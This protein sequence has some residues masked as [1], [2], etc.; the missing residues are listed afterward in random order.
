MHPLPKYRILDLTSWNRKEHFEFFNAFDQ[1]YFGLQT[2]VDVTGAKELCKTNGWSF[3]LF[4]HFLS[5]KAVNSVEAFKLRLVNEEIRIYENLHVNTNQF[6]EDRTFAFSFIPFEDD[7]EKF[8]NVGRKVQDAVNQSTGLCLDENTS[9]PDSIHYSTIPWVS[10]TGLT[11]ARNS[12]YIDSVPKISFGKLSR[13]DDKFFL[14]V[15]IH[16]H[17][18]LVDGYDVG[19]YLEAFQKLLDL[20]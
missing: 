9:R 20:S 6:R 3:F 5:Q 16:A 17:H 8:Q 10:F 7:W 13:R 14:P 15:S 12:S 1:P 18:A 2:K 4:Y 11:H 19:I